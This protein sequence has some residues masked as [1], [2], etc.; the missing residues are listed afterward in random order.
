MKKN[1]ALVLVYN[2]M[3]LS[4]ITLLTDYLTVF[5]PWEEWWDID[6]DGSINKE[7]IQTEDSFQIV[8]NKSFNQ[9]NIQDYNIKILI[10]FKL[11][12]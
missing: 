9:T 5:Q 10:A 1:K 2:G 12:F 3:S 4:E 7:M 6:T 11:I 8:P